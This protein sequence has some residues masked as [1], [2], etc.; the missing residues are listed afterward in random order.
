MKNVKHQD[1]FRGKPQNP[2]T[3][4]VLAI[5]YEDKTISVTE[6]AK[7]LFPK[8]DEVDAREFTGF[9]DKNN[10]DIFIGDIVKDDRVGNPLVVL[11]EDGGFCIKNKNHPTY[12][13][14]PILYVEIIGNIYENTGVANWKGIL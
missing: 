14:A 12:I 9:Y 10:K 11:F 4:R 2:Q 13:N 6:V 5:N 8:F 7:K 3:Y 1:C